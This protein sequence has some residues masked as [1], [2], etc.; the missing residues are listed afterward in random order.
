MLRKQLFM[1]KTYDVEV[2][3]FLTIAFFVQFS[4]CGY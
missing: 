3:C 1:T 2:N 4:M